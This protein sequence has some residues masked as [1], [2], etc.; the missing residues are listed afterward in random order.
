MKWMD[1]DADLITA[2]ICM[3]RS[4]PWSQDEHLDQSDWVKRCV[5]YGLIVMLNN[6]SVWFKKHH[7]YSTCLQVGMVQKVLVTEVSHDGNYYVGHNKS[8]DQVCP[9][10]LNRASVSRTLITSALLLAVRM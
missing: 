9:K 1:S 4:R 5:H 10:C 6:Y 7:I 2:E 3:S 8:Y